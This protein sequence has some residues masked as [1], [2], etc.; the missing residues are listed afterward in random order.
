MTQWRVCLELPR[1]RHPTF[2][3]S[4]RAAAL[5]KCELQVFWQESRGSQMASL[6]TAAPFSAV[7]AEQPLESLLE[8]L[9]KSPPPEETEASCLPPPV[10][11]EGAASALAVPPEPMHRKRALAYR[12]Q[13]KHSKGTNTRGNSIDGNKVALAAASPVSLP[14]PSSRSSPASHAVAGN[15]GNIFT[16]NDDESALFLE[17]ADAPDLGKLLTKPIEVRRPET[18][19]HRQY[20]PNF[21]ADEKPVNVSLSQDVPESRKP[22]NLASLVPVQ[23]HQTSKFESSMLPLPIAITAVSGSLKRISNSSASQDTFPASEAL[24]SDVTPRKTS[25]SSTCSSEEDSQEVITNPT[26]NKE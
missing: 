16:K 18:R 10:A 1:P 14:R 11:L 24:R 21:D 3:L 2:H 8:E 20:W 7:P 25:P 26:V 17:L 23:T 15:S 22:K 12:P 13:T 9:L 19:L 6:S 4:V 5:G